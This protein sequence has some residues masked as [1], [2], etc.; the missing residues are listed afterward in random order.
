M[1]PRAPISTRDD[2]VNEPNSKVRRGAAYQDAKTLAHEIAKRERLHEDIVFADA[3]HVAA[4]FALETEDIPYTRSNIAW[5]FDR[6]G[7]AEVHEILALRWN[8]PGDYELLPMAG[9]TENLSAADFVT[10]T[11]VAKNLTIEQIDAFFFS[12][13][14][15]RC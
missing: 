8:Y 3:M 14:V 1:L 6:I 2:Q 13:T 15:G 9:A 12:D 11:E 7:P 4:A 5:M 10:A